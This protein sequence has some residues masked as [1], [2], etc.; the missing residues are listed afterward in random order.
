MTSK[1]RSLLAWLVPILGAL[2]VIGGILWAL[3][4]RQD[5]IADELRQGLDQRITRPE[6][7]FVIDHM[8]SRFEHLEDFMWTL[9]GR[10][11]VLR[12]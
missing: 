6:M 8:D 3:I 7:Q 11:G 10:H 1:S 2:V 12:P 5:A 9:H 4:G